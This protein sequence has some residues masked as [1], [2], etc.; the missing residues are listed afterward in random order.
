MAIASG[1]VGISR[2]SL[3][4][5]WKE[6]RKHL[7]RAPQRDVLDY[8]EYDIDP[9]VWINRLLKRLKNGEYS[10]EKPERYP[11]AK[12]KGFNRIITVPA[13]PDLV[14]YRTIVDHLFRKARNKQHKH[15]YFSQSTL[16]KVVYQAGKD[17]WAEIEKYRDKGDYESASHSAFLEW[18]KFDQYRQLLIFD[19]IYPFVVLTDITNYFDS[20]LYGRIEESLYDLRAPSR[21]VSLLFTLLESLSIRESFTPVQRIGL[22]VDPCDCSRNL[23]HMALFPHDERMVELVGEDAYVRWMDDQ[24]FGASSKA[25]GLRILGAVG[26]SLRRLHLT[27]NAGKSKILSLREAKLHFHFA[28]NQDLEAIDSL[29]FDTNQQQQALRQALKSAWTSAQKNEGIGEWQKILKRFYRYAARGRTR[30]FKRRAK[31][32][33]MDFPALVDRIGDYMRY[34]VSVP[35]YLDFVDEILNDPEQVYADVN[36][37]LIESLLKLEPDKPEKTRLRKLAQEIHSGQRCFSGSENCKTLVPLMYLRFGDKRNIQK[38]A[39]SVGSHL[40]ALPAHVSRSICAVL[41]SCGS[42]EFA[43]VKAAAS[44]LLRN[45]LSEFVKMVDRIQG[46]KEVEGRFKNRIGLSRDS[47][48]GAKYIDM[49]SILSARLL[50]LCSHTPVTSWLASKKNTLLADDI[51]DFDKNLIRRLWP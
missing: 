16:S 35:E 19:K 4:N 5:A 8:I 46:F 51:S 6:V 17:A 2:S 39:G 37:Q 13:V 47:I 27:P 33:L 40:D 34:V 24:N 45:H 12:S 26:E 36:F 10:P 43:I 25:E 38:L 30:M 7:K 14:L 21:M 44:R 3:W 29:E 50:G 23:A 49:R 20:I 41:A 1:I 15:V 22:P 42:S 32:D 18:M 48:T 28:A 9:D 11:L 31:K